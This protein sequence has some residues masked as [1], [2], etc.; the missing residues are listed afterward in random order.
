MNRRQFQAAFTRIELF[1][2]LGVVV[3]LLFLLIPSFARVHPGRTPT[4]SCMTHQ[5]QINL[6]FTIFQEDNGGKFP[7]QLSTITNGTMELVANGHASVQFQALTYYIKSFA[8]FICPSDIHRQAPT[9]Y[10]SFADTNTSYFVN[11]DASG[12][13]EYTF[14]TG[15][16]HL[17]TD[18]KPIKPGLL[19]Y[20]KTMDMSWTHELHNI[21]MF[22]TYG[23]L[24]F[25]DGHSEIITGKNLNDTFRKQ[26]LE[27]ARLLVP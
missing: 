27:N 8:V 3:V 10:E 1:V 16:R 7:W 23:G 15:D 25:A 20:N 19:N 4:L 17:V 9:S 13:K 5:R 12:N 24:G 21:K 26:H 22:K 18:S 14:L 11:V 2:V 6:G